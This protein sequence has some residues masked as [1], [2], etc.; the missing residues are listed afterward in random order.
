MRIKVTDHCHYTHKQRGAAH[1]GCNL[2]YKEN[3]YISAIAH[4]SSGHSKHS[5]ILK[6]SEKFK[7]CNFLCIRENMREYIFFSLRTKFE[8]ERIY[9]MYVKVYQECRIC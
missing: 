8:K 4:N 7:E 9:M 5:L 3:I 1:L 6:I 2:R